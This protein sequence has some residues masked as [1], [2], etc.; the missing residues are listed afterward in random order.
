[1]YTMVNLYT[2]CFIYALYKV[3]KLMCVKLTYVTLI[4]KSVIACR[5]VNND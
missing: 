2:Q 1:M 3:V 5:S 4:L